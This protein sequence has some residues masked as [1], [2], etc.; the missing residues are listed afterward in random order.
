[1]MI[2]KWNLN[3]KVCGTRTLPESID[4]KDLPLF[5]TDPERCCEHFK[6]EPTKH[7]IRELQLLAWISG[8]RGTEGHTREF[9]HEREEK[10]GLI[11]YNPILMWT[12]A[13]VWLYHAMYDIPV[14]P[15]YTQGYRSLGCAPCSEPYTET[16]RGGR[17]AG[18]EKCGGECG[19]H[20]KDLS[21]FKKDKDGHII[22]DVYGAPKREKGRF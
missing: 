2:D 5:K 11:K 6:V 15:L 14:H 19:I 9:L 22:R 20:T 10:Q 17:W 7:A 16:E 13:E 3:I 18:N 12:E 21:C 8:L 4:D 1:M